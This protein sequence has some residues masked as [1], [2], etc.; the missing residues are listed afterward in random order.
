MT[1]PQRPPNQQQAPPQLTKTE[2]TH[3]FIA[4]KIGMVP[5]LRKED[6]IFQAK[7]VG[8]GI[9]VGIAAM[10]FIGPVWWDPEAPFTVWIIVGALFGMIG[11]AL[12]SGAIIGVR[13]IWR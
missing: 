7:F 10:S 2:E 11:G 9:F 8:I 4:D 3:Q 5:S 12:I 1:E 13:N 6:N